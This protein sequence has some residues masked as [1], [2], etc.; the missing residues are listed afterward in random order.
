RLRG[1]R[2]AVRAIF[3]DLPGGQR[4]LV[5][6]D[7]E[8]GRAE[9]GE[10]LEPEGCGRAQEENAREPLRTLVAADPD[11]GERAEILPLGPPTAD[12]VVRGAGFGGDGR[13]RGGRRGAPGGD[14]R[15]DEPEDARCSGAATTSARPL[16]RHP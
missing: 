14:Q 7:D 15:G 3:E 9:R 16:A 2:H 5:A 12:E 10:R 13:R 6:R 1:R 4:A 11:V 8:D